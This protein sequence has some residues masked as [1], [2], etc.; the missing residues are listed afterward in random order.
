MSAAKLD[1]ISDQQPEK[2]AANRRQ[3]GFN[4]QREPLAPVHPGDAVDSRQLIEQPHQLAL[5]E[6]I[7]VGRTGK[8]QLTREGAAVKVCADLVHLV[9]VKRLARLPLDCGCKAICRA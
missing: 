4:D 1:E 5:L 9:M 8:Y 2:E 3:S 7:E 6:I